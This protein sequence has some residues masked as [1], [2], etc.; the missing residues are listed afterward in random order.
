VGATQ[1]QMI[2]IARCGSYFIGAFELLQFSNEAK[3]HLKNVSADIVIDEY[4]MFNRAAGVPKTYRGAMV[5]KVFDA[6]HCGGEPTNAAFC[7]VP[8]NSAPEKMAEKEAGP[9]QQTE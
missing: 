1:D 7:S 5:W 8:S 3:C 4:M 9:D 6:C 2:A